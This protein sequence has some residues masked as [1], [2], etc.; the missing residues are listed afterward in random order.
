MSNEELLEEGPLL[1][2]QNAMSP[3]EVIQWQAMEME[4]ISSEHSEAEPMDEVDDE[5]ED[6]EPEDP[7]DE[8][9]LP[10]DLGWYFD[11]F[12]LS[13]KDRIRLCS[14]Y[15]SMLRAQE[16]FSSKKKRKIIDLTKD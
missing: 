1:Q 4:E 10:L 3:D 12:E 6:E 11:Q 9:D 14:T 5:G 2:R 13:P 8:D 7:D 15:A 16:A